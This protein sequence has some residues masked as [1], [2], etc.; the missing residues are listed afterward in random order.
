MAC[1][2]GLEGEAVE[3]WLEP[4][5]KQCLALGVRWE[6]RT[7]SCGEEERIGQVVLF[8]FDWLVCFF[9]KAKDLQF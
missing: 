3:E 4:G 9:K 5:K 7:V 2:A 6:G 1:G 8:L